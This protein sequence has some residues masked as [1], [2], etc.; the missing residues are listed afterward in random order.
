[1]ALDREEVDLPRPGL[2]LED[3]TLVLAPGSSVPFI[4]HDPAG[5]AV[6]GA[7]ELGDVAG[8]FLAP[9]PGAARG[10][11]AVVAAVQDPDHPA[12]AVAVVVVVAG[13]DVA[14]GVQAGLVV[15]PLAVGEDLELRCRRG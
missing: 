15:V 3:G 2:G 11:V 7:D 13:E 4:D 9:V 6:A 10:A 12:A 1:M 5:A 14:E 8:D